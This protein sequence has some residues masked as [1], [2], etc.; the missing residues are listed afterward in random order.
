VPL[1]IPTVLV[2][3]PSTASILVSTP[4]ETGRGLTPAQL[5]EIVS[6]LA[7]D[8]TLV[9]RVPISSTDRTW[10]G[11]DVGPDVCAWVIRWPLGVSSGWHDH[12]GPATGVS[13]A[14]T[15]LAGQLRERAWS[16]HGAL[17]RR[18][19]TGASRSFGP[20]YIHEVIGS[21][22]GAAI[23]LHA[24]SPRLTSMRAYRIEGPDLVDVETAEP[25]EG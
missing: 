11:I 14:F 6:E 10:A 3:E 15:V 12:G 8:P 19:S 18:L 4:A 17:T 2:E 24:Y 5:R 25:D 1:S 9:D 20:S 13:G 16:P 23:S 22:A 7:Q 21:S